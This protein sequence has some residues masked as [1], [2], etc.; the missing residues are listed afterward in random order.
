MLDNVSRL[1][2]DNPFYLLSLHHL[3]QLTLLITFAALGL[4]VKTAI[5]SS[6]IPLTHHRYTF[7][8]HLSFAELLKLLLFFQ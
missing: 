3:G 5:T 1:G 8:H 2:R 4:A 7:R 6:S